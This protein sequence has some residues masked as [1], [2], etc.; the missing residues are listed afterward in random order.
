M[1]PELDQF[2]SI[3]HLVATYVTV[4]LIFF[5]VFMQRRYYKL[6]EETLRLQQA[7]IHVLA[8]AIFGQDWRKQ[9]PPT[10]E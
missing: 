1:T 2:F 4:V 8:E 10:H 6:T 7:Q 3:F 5:A 9:L